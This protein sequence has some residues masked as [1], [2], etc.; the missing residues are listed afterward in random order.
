MDWNKR[1][2]HIADI[3]IALQIANDLNS[4]LLLL[5]VDW[6]VNIQLTSSVCGHWYLLDGLGTIE[7][8]LNMCFKCLKTLVVIDTNV[9]THAMSRLLYKYM[10]E[11]GEMYDW[12]DR[13]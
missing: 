7:A 9:T 1:Y 10:S 2:E 11:K 3:T 8:G 5:H 4:F 6:Y 13:S 12:Y